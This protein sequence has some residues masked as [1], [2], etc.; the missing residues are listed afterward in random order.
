MLKAKGVNAM[1]TAKS[2]SSPEI[3]AG[4]F[5]S[6]ERFDAFRKKMIDYG[7]DVT[8]LDFAKQDWLEFDFSRL[9]FVIY[10]P[11][12][13]FASNHPL[14]LQEVYD[15]IIFLQ[16]NWPK[17]KIFPDPKIV[18]YYNDKY[19]QFLFLGQHDY[20]IPRT[21]PLFSEES[22]KRADRLLGYPMVV[23]NRYGAGGGSVFRIHSL[24]EL[25]QLYR[26]SKLDLFNLGSARYFWNLFSKRMFYYHLIK[27]RQM[28]YPFL[29]TPLLAQ[30]FVKMDRDLKTVIGNR[31]VVEAHWRFQADETMW[32]V[33]IDG[34][35]IGVWGEVPQ[36]ALDLST[37]LATD[38]NADWLNIDMIM[39]DGKFLIT[40][41]SPVWHHYAYREKPTFEYRDD[42]NIDVPLEVSLDLER[43]IV[44]SLIDRV[45]EGQTAKG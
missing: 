41:F 29:S 27:A 42:Y 21:I 31:K 13:K 15:N 28:P 17:L 45:K 7:I 16:E 25:K 8:L 22:V 44:E 3:R 30:K 32:K 12:F 5:K 39:E 24:K 2:L 10:Y 43:I 37:R 35:G 18:K 34:G 26:L 19:R 33:N 6:I 14:A 1:T 40:E 23:K 11:S 4:L 36:E 9:D 20:P 38:L